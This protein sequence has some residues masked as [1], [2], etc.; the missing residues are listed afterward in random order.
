[1]SRSGEDNV[2]V[3]VSGAPKGRAANIHGRKSSQANEG[4]EILVD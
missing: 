4:P 2:L 3:G 1:M